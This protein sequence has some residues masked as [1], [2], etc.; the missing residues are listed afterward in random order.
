MD[1]TGR[2]PSAT[3]PLSG[4][5]GR[6]Q[7]TTNH[8][9]VPLVPSAQLL[10]QRLAVL[11][12]PSAISQH[13]LQ[14]WP[15]VGPAGTWPFRLGFGHAG[16]GLCFQAGTDVNHIVPGLRLGLLPGWRRSLGAARRRDK[17]RQQQQDKN[18]CSRSGLVSHGF[19]PLAPVLVH[20]VSIEPARATISTRLEGYIATPGYRASAGYASIRQGVQS[21]FPTLKT[22]PPANA[23]QRLRGPAA[24]RLRKKLSTDEG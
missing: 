15:T 5:R 1:N 7:Q 11:F 2:I 9:L 23:S 3:S 14:W 12:R 19:Y 13:R 24:C 17:G 8:R 21:E 20:E 4:D 6:P 16:A 10:G 22:A 18:R